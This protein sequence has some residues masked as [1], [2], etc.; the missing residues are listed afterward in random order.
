MTYLV[1]STSISTS[2]T[3]NNHMDSHGCTLGLYD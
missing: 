2:S 1:T 3:N